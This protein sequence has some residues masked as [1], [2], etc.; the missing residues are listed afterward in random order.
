MSDPRHMHEFISNKRGLCQ[1][2]VGSSICHKE[3]QDIVHE[4]FRASVVTEEVITNQDGAV[5]ESSQGRS[6]S[7]GPTVDAEHTCQVFY[8]EGMGHRGVIVCSCGF[9]I[10]WSVSESVTQES[11]KQAHDAHLAQQRELLEYKAMYLGLC[12]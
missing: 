8:S 1:Q 3:S 6:L 11:F 5:V 2:I 12:K 9:A 7:Y 10:T 4:R